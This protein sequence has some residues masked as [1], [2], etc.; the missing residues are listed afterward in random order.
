MKEALGLIRVSTDLQDTAR[1]KT[2]LQ[3]LEKRYGIHIIRTLEL[4][5]VSGTTMLTNQQ[6]RQLLREV[7][8][9]G[10]HGLACSAVDRIVRPKKGRDFGIL[11]DLQDAKKH[12]WTIRDGHMDLGTHEGWQRAMAAA[13]RAG[14]ELEEIIRRV[15]DGKAQ[16]KAEGRNVN[17]SAV[18]PDGLKFDKRQGWS[19]DP[20][21]LAKITQAYQLLFEDRYRL[22]EIERLVGWPRRRCRTLANPTWRGVRAYPATADQDAFEVPLPLEPV[23]TEE[24]W[25]RAQALLAKRRTWSRETSDQRHLGGG[26]LFCQCGRRLYSRCDPRRGQHD[27]YF[28]S[29]KWPKG[30]GCGAAHIRR[31][32]VDAAIVRIV[33]EYLTAPKFLAAVFRRVKE[34][35]QRD[36]RAEREKEL[37][38]MAARRKKWIEQYDEDR[39]NKQEFEHKMDAV[40][41]AVRQIEAAMPAAPSPVLDQRAVIAGL[42]RTLARFNT[43]PFQEQRATLKRAVRSFQVVDDA[44][45]EFT[46]SGAFLGELAHTNPAQRLRSQCS[47]R[48]PKPA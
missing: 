22:S 3:K 36:T 2:D 4:V 7:T 47:A 29:S 18:L 34:T 10:L 13:L 26:L 20:V 9:P 30:P 40:T 41:K 37:A 27:T 38:K 28:C 48:F 42:V 35:P 23:V 5:G 39:I 8:Q 32:T 19:Y 25:N 15:R 6:T 31:V 11:D 46:L 44:I 16:K 17:G 33:G 24:Q 14:S 1:Q 45:T 12:L 43:W 21:E